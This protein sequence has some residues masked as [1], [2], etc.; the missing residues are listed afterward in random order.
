MS[1]TKLHIE[2]FTLG[3]WMT[4]CF[5][6]VP[7]HSDG[8]SSSACW[9][10][11]VGFAPDS[12]IEYVKREQLQ[13]QAVLLTHAHLDHIAGLGAVRKHWPDLPILIHDAEVDFL[14]DPMLNLSAMAPVP[15]VAEPASTG[16]LS[17]GEV[18]DL[19]GVRC[20]L[21]HTPGHSPGGLTFYFPDHEIAIVGDTLFR[22]GIGRFDFP[23]SDEAILMASLREQLMT[24]PDETRV[25]PGHMDETTIGRERKM[26]PYLV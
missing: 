19:A 7:Q 1:E 24:L 22:D 12:M 14:V 25:L 2:E 4:N 17:H 10:V 23:T 13:P 26:N 11:D 18:L 20:E 8:S 3:D 9:L 16:T 5:V 21:R 15:L 6:V